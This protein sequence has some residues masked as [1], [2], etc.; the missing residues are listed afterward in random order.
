[1]LK[2]NVEE[3]VNMT[4]MLADL[5][6]TVFEVGEI[7]PTMYNMQAVEKVLVSRISGVEQEQINW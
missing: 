3:W 1:M 4:P 2:A 5:Q 6:V 7:F